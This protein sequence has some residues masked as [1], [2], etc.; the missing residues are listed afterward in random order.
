MIGSWCNEKK[1]IDIL[2]W[3]M[4]LQK[5]S[6][7][8]AYKILFDESLHKRLKACL[9]G[10]LEKYLLLWTMDTCELDNV[11][12]YEALQ[13]VGKNKDRV[14]IDILYTRIPTQI[15]MIMQA[16]HV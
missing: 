8:E 15:Y 11:L 1:V 13:K 5:E 3:R 2:G 12:L 9:S 10:K 4:Q 14:A 6:I 7:V 16:Y